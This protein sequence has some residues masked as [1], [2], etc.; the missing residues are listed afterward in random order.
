MRVATWSP[1]LTRKGPGL[2]LRDIVEGEAQVEAVV[3]VIRAAEADVLLLTGIDMDLRGATLAE[4]A[5]RLEAAGAPYPHLF[6]AAGNTGLRSGLDL[7]GDERLDEPE[8]A[9]G[10]GRFPG[11]GGMALLSRLPLGEVVELTGTL[12]RDLPG[13]DPWFASAAAAEAQRLSS[14]AHWD[15]P[16]LTTAG[17]LHLLTLAA[18]PPVFDGEEDR[19]GRRAEDELRLWQV[20]LDGALGG[21]PQGPAVVIGKLNVDPVDGEGRRAVFAALTGGPL[22]DPAPEGPGGA[23]EADATHEGPP[24][25]DTVDWDGPGNLRVDYILPQSGLTVAAS[26]VL[27]P[28][29]A[30]PLGGLSLATVRA[31]SR[32]R[33]VWVDLVLDG[34]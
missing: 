3:A 25:Q 18:G 5:N 29:E 33:L 16:V 32:H 15:V 19:N 1:E 8:D 13:G 22:Q 6:T 31:A 4:L 30:A 7:D 12:W 9:Q 10:F 28:E 23:A 20:Y 24:A 27:W 14:V 26:G 2:L 34:E 11:E 17:P 21:P